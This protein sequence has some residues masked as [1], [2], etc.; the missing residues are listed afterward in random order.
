MKKLAVTITLLTTVI[1]VQI[2]PQSTFAKDFGVYGTLFEIKEEGFLSMI[3][4]KLKLIDIEKEH[5]KMLDIAK[6]KVIEPE[7]V[8]GVK[9]TS[10]TRSF[11]Y[12][13]SYTL[14]EDIVLPNGN[15][16]YKAGARVNPLDHISL[17]KKLV[18]INGRDNDQVEWFKDQR[19]SSNILEKDKLVLVAGRPIELGKQ[20]NQE[21]YFDQAGVLTTKFGIQQVPAI[22]EQEDDKFRIN[23]IEV[24]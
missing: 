4:R 17:D 10:K 3:Q 14:K 24:K 5:K 19:K 7:A 23:E 18:F 1:A 11:T 20:L 22:A 9:A 8:K 21:V 16:L 12:D 2:L 13:P 6:N 15:V